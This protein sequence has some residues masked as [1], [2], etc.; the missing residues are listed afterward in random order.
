MTSQQRGEDP[1]SRISALFIKSTLNPA[2]ERD[3]GWQEPAL[4][5]PPA[6]Q[7]SFSWPLHSA[8]RQLFQQGQHTVPIWP[9][10][11]I[12]PALT[13]Q[14][15]QL[16]TSHSFMQQKAFTE[17]PQCVRYNNVRKS[18]SI[19]PVWVKCEK[20]TPTTKYQRGYLQDS[21]NFYMMKTEI[22]FLC[23]CKE[24]GVS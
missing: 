5:T 6:L 4:H 21:L 18:T 10:C 20:M 8:G 9:W 11:R 24:G 12:P 3:P 7:A 2:E 14:P 19:W 17:N 1:S 22:I 15:P 13:H 23:I 16:T